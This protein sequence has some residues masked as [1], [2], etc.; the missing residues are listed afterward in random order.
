M[1]R[2][3]IEGR[4]CKVFIK[5]L[6]GKDSLVYTSDKNDTSDLSSYP[7]YSESKSRKFD[8]DDT[9]KIID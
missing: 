5:D 4:T 9:P 7:K 8:D 2:A 3:V 6:S 1:N